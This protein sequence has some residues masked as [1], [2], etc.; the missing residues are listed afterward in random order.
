MV[1]ETTKVSKVIVTGTINEILAWLY[2]KIQ[3]EKG[4][5]S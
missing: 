2:L 5:G 3:Y 4:H 1:Q